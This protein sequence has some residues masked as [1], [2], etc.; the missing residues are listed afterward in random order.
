[1]LTRENKDTTIGSKSFNLT[2]SFL[3]CN[4]IHCLQATGAQ[5][6]EQTKMQLGVMTANFRAH[7]SFIST[8]I[9]ASVIC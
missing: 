1:M 7:A 3:Q 4:H 8:F 2:D 9:R 5:H 6:M